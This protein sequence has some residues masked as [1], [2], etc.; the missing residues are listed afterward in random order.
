M[1]CK[2][3][4]KSPIRKL[5][6][7]S[8]RAQNK[9]IERLT[10]TIGSN[11]EFNSSQMR[12]SRV[13]I[14]SRKPRNSNQR[15]AITRSPDMISA[16]EKY[17]SSEHVSQLNGSQLKVSE[18]PAPFDVGDTMLHSGVSNMR[19]PD[20]EPGTIQQVMEDPEDTKGLDTMS[21]MSDKKW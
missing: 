6:K 3:T 14:V 16:G 7:R 5:A 10:G 11:S 15:R 9:S 20:F 12:S 2:K 21:K 17:L 4:R 18:A 8:L 19:S 1:K 13:K